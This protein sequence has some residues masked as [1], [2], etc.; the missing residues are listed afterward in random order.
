MLAYS[1]SCFAAGAW[2]RA[3]VAVVSPPHVQVRG[4][5]GR[6]RVL[7]RRNGIM[8]VVVGA[9]EK[10]LSGFVGAT[11]SPRSPLGVAVVAPYLAQ[12]QRPSGPAR[13]L[14]RGDGVVQ[15][16]VGAWARGA[17]FLSDCVSDVV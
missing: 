1:Y 17:E 12:V 15:A 3:W 9:W 10:F 14:P 8:Q 7:S 16:V 4:P 13:V 5:S 2:S 6:A 11:A